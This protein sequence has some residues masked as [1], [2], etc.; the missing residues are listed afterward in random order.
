MGINNI[1]DCL[2]NTKKS[3]ILIDIYLAL[4]VFLDKVNVFSF[5]K[6]KEYT[7]EDIKRY[8]IARIIYG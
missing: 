1:L 6:D 5:E 4:R 8:L 2:K 7:R 3:I